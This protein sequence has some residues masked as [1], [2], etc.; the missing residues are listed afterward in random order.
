MREEGKDGTRRSE[1]P[2]V[3]EDKSRGEG[4]LFI[5]DR[6]ELI[7]EDSIEPLDIMRPAAQL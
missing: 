4:E 3:E 1:G 7:R 6:N 2:G 5:P